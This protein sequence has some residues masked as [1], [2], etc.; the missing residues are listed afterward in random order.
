RGDRQEIEN[1]ER[2]V[3]LA[4]SSKHDYIQL[5]DKTQGIDQILSRRVAVDVRIAEAFSVLPDNVEVSQLSVNGSTV[6][7][8]VESKNLDAL[9]T[10]LDTGLAHISEGEKVAKVDVVSFSRDSETG[11]YIATVLIAYSE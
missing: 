1:L 3:R 4:L 2:E 6:G 5:V 9:N 7:F 10:M 11:K 8:S